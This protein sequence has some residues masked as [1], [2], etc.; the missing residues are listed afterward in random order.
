MADGV[1]RVL[2]LD[3]IN[4]ALTVI[5]PDF[6]SSGVYC[7]RLRHINNKSAT[8]VAESSVFIISYE[9]RI[10]TSAILNRC[11]ALNE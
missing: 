4:A 1:S 8:S 6:A 3:F 2:Y 5:T 10:I 9:E 7:G 11:I